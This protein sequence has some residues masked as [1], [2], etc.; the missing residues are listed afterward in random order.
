MIDLD[1]LTITERKA[2]ERLKKLAKG[3]PKTLALFSNAGSLEVH[4]NSR[5]GE[6]FTND[7]YIEEVYGIANDGGDRD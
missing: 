2:I 3:W 4:K 1:E 5:D 7:T 6:P